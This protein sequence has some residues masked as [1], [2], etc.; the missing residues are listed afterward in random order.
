MGCGLPVFTPTFE[1]VWMSTL[2]GVGVDSSKVWPK[3]AFT[4]LFDF[5]RA[6][7][8]AYQTSDPI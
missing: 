6:P 5:R 2:G 4:A 7:V 1:A 8:S 3:V